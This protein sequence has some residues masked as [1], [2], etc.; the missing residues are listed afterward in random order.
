MT[1]H[2]LRPLLSQTDTMPY[3]CFFWIKE[4]NLTSPL[5][6]R[7]YK[8]GL[9]SPYILKNVHSLVLQIVFL[10]FESCENN[11]SSDCLAISE[12]VLLSYLQNFYAPCHDSSIDSS[13]FCEK[14]KKKISVTSNFSF[15]YIAFTDLYP[16]D[17]LNKGLFDEGVYTPHVISKGRPGY[18]MI[19]N[20]VKFVIDSIGSDSFSN[21]TSELIRSFLCLSSCCS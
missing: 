18:T 5:P 11:A 15:T 8:P 10:Y 9:H 17:R 2:L 13:I 21:L 3:V 4:H 7:C 14:M 1:S 16:Q 12:V 6:S 20:N 19:I